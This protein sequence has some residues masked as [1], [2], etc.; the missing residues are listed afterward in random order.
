MSVSR[1]ELFKLAAAAGVAGLLGRLPGAAAARPIAWRNWSG[2]QS[3]L[4]GQRFAPASE[5]ELAAWLRNVEGVVRPVGSG[6]SFS[7]LV[8][9]DGSIVSLSR[10]SGMIG[11]DPATLQAEFRAGTPMS[12]MG[13]PLSAMERSD[14]SSEIS[15]VWFA[16]PTT[17]PSRSTRAT[18]SSTSARVSSFTI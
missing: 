2:A 3:S 16:G 17:V 18:G 7:P 15:K 14:P 5:T 10:L 13:A 4:P 11:H 12:Q 6:H 1:R 9:T 8:P